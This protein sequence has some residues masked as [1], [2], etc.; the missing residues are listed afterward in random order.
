[1]KPN[2]L[3]VLLALSIPHCAVA[4]DHVGT[5]VVFTL[6]PREAVVAADS[7]LSDAATKRVVANDICKILVFDNKYI[8]AAAGYAGPFGNV[9]IDTV[10]KEVYRK[11]PIIS[12]ADFANRW[13]S[14]VIPLLESYPPH[15][16][17]TDPT[18]S[19]VFIGIEHGQ[20]VA[21]YVPIVMVGGRVIPI[22]AMIPPQ[23]VPFGMGHPFVANEFFENRTSRAKRWHKQIDGLALRGKTMAI[24]NL[25]LKLDKTGTLGGAIDSVR[26]TPSGIS[27][28][29][30][31]KNCQ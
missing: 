11:G 24:L 10:T 17:S 31:K 13:I 18:L 2:T 14:A 28:L 26:A 25:T 5:I 21:H 22:K 9:H 19:A 23:G 8:F 15:R 16:E 12:S 20:I 3:I 4:Q 29:S 27:W 30:L 6:S 7:N 1:M